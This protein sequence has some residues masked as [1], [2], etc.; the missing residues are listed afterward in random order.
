M[1]RLAA[2]AC[3]AIVALSCV[4]APPSDSPLPDA[5]FREM[6]GGA[7]FDDWPRA[8][9]RA[10][11]Q[12]GDNGMPTGFTDE[13][14]ASGLERPTAL[15]FLPDG[16]ILVTEQAGLLK[17]VPA[18]SG[19]PRLVLDLR[20]ETLSN[21]QLGLLGMALDPDYPDEPYVYLAYTR[22]APLGGQA[23]TYG[24]ADGRDACPT[25]F[26]CPGSAR[27]V[28]YR[29]EGQPV[30]VAGEARVLIDDWCITGPNHT[31]GAIAFGPE[32]A[33]YVGGGD[34]A[35]GDDA[36]FGQLGNQ[37]NPCADAQDQGGSLRSQDARLGDDPVGLGG[38]IVR[39]D[40]ATG[41]GLA[42][43]PLAA[44]ADTNARRILA[45]GL[46]NP[47]RFTFRPATGELWIADVGWNTYEE[48]NLLP[49]APGAEPVNFGWPCFE[50]PERQPIWQ[51]FDLA[52]CAT[53][54]E[55]ESA[56][57]F[58]TFSFARGREG[59]L[60]CDSRS[61]ATSAIAFYEG[62]AFPDR[63]RGALF[64]ADMAQRCLYVIEAGADGRP[65]PRTARLF[66]H[67]VRASDLVV[68]PDGA[69]YY[70]ELM[71]GEIRRISWR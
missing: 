61:A 52:A 64:F 38:T 44:S 60:A 40:R 17:A 13:V 25:R 43:N 4:A 2:V 59:E 3:L 12:P 66:A 70:P 69:I 46:R 45:M 5:P 11:P 23:P 67:P 57:T 15:R 22:D 32:G 28:R 1:S 31:I 58:P 19:E 21:Y 36:D 53:L 27:L 30:S 35:D 39:V 48:I 54:Y 71:S 20:T 29:L 41:Q 34:G 51:A 16:T 56:V 68:G 18:G 33:L 37:D 55:D 65:D 26:A 62:T 6:N 47:F 10:W 42:D 7:V 24:S 9:R 49:A 14:I 50:G 63:F 8:A